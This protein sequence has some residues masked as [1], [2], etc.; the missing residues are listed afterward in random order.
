MV[1]KYGKWRLL[2]R[3]IEWIGIYNVTVICALRYV[4]IYQTD[5]L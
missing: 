4:Q 2:D 1:L 5:L 3:T